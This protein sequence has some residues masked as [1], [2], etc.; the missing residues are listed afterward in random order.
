VPGSPFA[1]DFAPLP[2]HATIRLVLA[3]RARVTLTVRTL[4][5]SRIRFLAQSVW[6][7]P[8]EQT[9]AWDGRDAG[10]AVV[11]DGEYMVRVLAVN[12]SGRSKRLQRP[13]R[14]GM[15]PVFPANPAAIVIAVDPGHGGRYPGAVRDGWME[16]D[17]NLAIGLQLQALLERAG[18]TVVMSRTTDR[19]LDEPPT[20][21]NGDGKFDRYDDDLLRNDSANLARADVN[22]HIHNNASVSATAR[23]TK[24]FTS[25]DR[26]WTP[27]GLRL[28]DMVVNE[29][30]RALQAFADRNFA[31]L[32]GGSH[33]GWYYYVGPY[34]P[35]Y[36]PRP[37][38]AVS[39]LSES[40]YVS[41]AS[42]REALKRADVRLSLAAAMYI[43]LAQY[44]NTRELGIG[45]EL[46][47]GPSPS[48]AAGSQVEYRV[49]MTNRGNSPSSGWALQLHYVPQ[50]PL[51]DGSGQ[52]GDLI[53]SV[54]VPDGVG[55]GQS[56]DITV[57]ATAPSSAGDWLVKGDVL[58]PDT[59]YASAAGIVAIQLPLTTT[60]P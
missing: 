17:F 1:P 22:L 56:V 31:P 10:G 38:L 19:A 8:G 50:V 59:S 47:S 14:K 24:S 46:L 52:L 26:T 25:L 54:A 32:N 30:F 34:D 12:E 41:N 18:V 55:P 51:Y 27:S 43:A 35:P 58:L 21:W 7:D 42:E 28:A 4:D 60:T 16:K 33:G 3:R 40:L 2:D 5:G 49:R 57:N 20:D 23:G 15:P 13:L 36:L 6:L 45:Y 29:E 11:A 48:V 9:W 53:G 37:A 39:V 44:L